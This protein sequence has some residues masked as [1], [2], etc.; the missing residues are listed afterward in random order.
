MANAPLIRNPSNGKTK[1]LPS[2]EKLGAT[3]GQLD[4]VDLTGLTDGDTVR[5][6]GTTQTFERAPSA[7]LTPA[8]Q[9]WQS[10]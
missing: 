8:E 6:N 10:L 2:A 3:L 9:F 7:S 1:E 5:Y 4:N